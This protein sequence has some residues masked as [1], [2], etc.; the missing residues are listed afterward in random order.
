MLQSFK[1]LGIRPELVRRLRESGIVR[2]T[3]VQAEAIPL[4]AGGH[5]VMAEAQTGTGKTLAFI[6]PMLERI[7][8][9][10]PHVQGLVLTP[11]REL[12]IQ[13][14]AELEKL[15]PVTGVNVLAVYGGQDVDRQL[16]KLQ[17]AVHFIVATPGRLLDHLRRGSVLL[18]RLSML[19][20]DEA[21]QMLHLGFL[22][23][24]ESVLAQTPHQKQTMLFSATMPAQ[25]RE[26]ARE[27]MKEPRFVRIRPD[28]QVTLAEIEQRVVLTT[29]RGKQ[30]ALCRAI[31]EANPFLA[32]IFCR[33]KRRASTLNGALLERGYASEE[34]HGDLSQA[35]REQVMK[36]F[37]EA[38]FQLLVAT[39]VAARGLD[40][41]GVTHV[42]NYDIPHD[43]ESY[44]HRIGRTGRAGGTG[45]A[46]TFAAPKDQRYLELIEQ[47][48]RM[49]LP[50][51]KA[52]GSDGTARTA[53]AERESGRKSAGRA[54]TSRAT[55]S[56]AASANRGEARRGGAGQGGT[57]RGGSRG[58]A[59]TTG[60]RG[61][62]PASAGRKSASSR[63][64]ATAAGRA[65]GGRGARGKR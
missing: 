38:K 28:K 61:T 18:R 40:V 19:V 55:G 39:D 2:P 49:T 62:Q 46:I 3:P 15:A 23:E 47:S 57:Y 48:I 44:I 42:F 21:D 43:A 29:D 41:E 53:E 16:R 8:P 25:V 30:D 52:G 4:I 7:D 59:G 51:S 17:G 37:R 34:L 63:G 6:L 5:D 64:A 14:T 54:A 65:K 9:N 31:D 45:V 60:P 35:K 11:T 32:M 24:V 27:V 10:V 12:A 13:I 36:R 20:L 1:P 22:Q 50:K 56:R 33:T 58:R 26:L